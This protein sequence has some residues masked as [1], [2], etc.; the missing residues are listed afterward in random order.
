MSV[1][2]VRHFSKRK[3][4]LGMRHELCLRLLLVCLNP[5]PSSPEATYGERWGPGKYMAQI[6]SVPGSKKILEYVD[7]TF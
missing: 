2:V 6:V 7:I 3:K 5:D 4:V 1:S